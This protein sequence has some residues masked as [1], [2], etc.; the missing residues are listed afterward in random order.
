[1]NRRPPP[2]WRTTSSTEVMGSSSMRSMITSRG[3]PASSAVVRQLGGDAGRDALDN[4]DERF[5][6][7][8]PRRQITNHGK[9]V[10][11]FECLGVYVPDLREG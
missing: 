4:A 1:M 5:S 6:V 10:W 8:L 9:S 11:V 7:R 3:R 2:N